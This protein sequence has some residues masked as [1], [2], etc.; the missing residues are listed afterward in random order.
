M[1]RA[2][3]EVG[4]TQAGLAETAA[5]ERTALAKVESG[6]RRLYA[7]ELARIAEALRRPADWFLRPD[8]DLPA[9]LREKRGEI[10]AIA[11]RH[12][13]SNVRVFGSIARGEATPD[14]DI[15][16]LVDLKD[17]G[18]LLDIVRLELELRELLECDVD[19]GTADSLKQRIRD[20]ALQ[21]AIAL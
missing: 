10:L 17:D 2:R 18:S 8:R 19:I 4:L 3:R 9:L 12:G 14:S 21:E 20:R 16:L 1:A 5:I 11:E 6:R 13:A 15:D 7:E